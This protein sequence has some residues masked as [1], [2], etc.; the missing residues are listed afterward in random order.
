MFT[1]FFP[2]ATALYMSSKN[3]PLK[4]IR[5]DDHNSLE[6]VEIQFE[7]ILGVNKTDLNRIKWK[8][9]TCPSMFNHSANPPH[10]DMV[11]E[12][13]DAEILEFEV[14]LTVVP[15][16][17]G[18]GTEVIVRQNTQF[19][20]AERMAYRHRDLIDSRPLTTNK[21]REAVC[22]A[23][24]QIPFVLHGLWKTIGTG[25]KLDVNNTA[26]VYVIS[27]FAYLWMIL[28]HVSENTPNTRHGQGRT[29]GQDLDSIV[30]GKRNHAI[31]GKRPKYRTPKNHTL[32][33]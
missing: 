32:P 22:N 4:Y 2:I 16:F 5:V 15:T 11:P 27:D 13:D 20:L 26:D 17:A 30:F 24:Y 23:D 25:I 8:S 1:T 19:T 29:P 14:K 10:V 7:D 33:D 31:Q 3:I 28:Q 18:K 9:G 12:L 6:I 21:L